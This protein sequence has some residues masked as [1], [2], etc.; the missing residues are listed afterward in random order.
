VNKLC[1]LWDGQSPLD[2]DHLA[3]FKSHSV[4]RAANGEF[5]TNIKLR[6][7][8]AERAMV[9]VVPVFQ[10]IEFTLGKVEKIDDC[11]QVIAASDEKVRFPM[12]VAARVLGLKSST[13]GY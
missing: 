5:L 7:R 6:G 10:L 11:G 13:G 3:A 12:A 2:A 8:A 9:Y 4:A 1:S